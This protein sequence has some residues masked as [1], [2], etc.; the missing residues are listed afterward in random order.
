MCLKIDWKAVSK[1]KAY[2]TLKKSC[3]HG[4]SKPIFWKD[5]H[6]ERFQKFLG[7]AKSHAHHRGVD[8]EVVL[9]E[10]GEECEYKWYPHFISSKKKFKRGP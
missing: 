8:L 7:K 1:T 3:F 9:T 10:W 4:K 5:Y 6:C 2:R